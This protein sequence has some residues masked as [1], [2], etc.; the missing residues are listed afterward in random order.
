MNTDTDI[1]ILFTE[2]SNFNMNILTNYTQGILY[3]KAPKILKGNIFISN[4]NTHI[5]IKNVKNIIN[6]PEIFEYLQQFKSIVFSYCGNF[7]TKLHEGL[8]KLVVTNIALYSENYDYLPSTLKV[9]IIYDDNLISIDH[10][11]SSLEVLGIFSYV[12]LNN[13][14]PNLRILR[15]SYYQSYVDNNNIQNNIDNNIDNIPDSIEILILENIEYITYKI[16]KL[17]KMLKNIYLFNSDSTENDDDFN[18][19]EKLDNIIPDKTII[20]ENTNI[21]FIKTDT[22]MYDELCSNFHNLFGY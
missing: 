9:L 12:S 18:F 16:Q 6:Y 7:A 13:L 4:N 5:N 21:E 22:E 1:D 14:P 20:P 17:P 10:L 11:P 15:I 8:E 19:E 2:L 3:D